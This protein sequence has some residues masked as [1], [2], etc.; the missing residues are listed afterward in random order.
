[1]SL[2]RPEVNS[3]VVGDSV[4]FE[5]GRTIKCLGRIVRVDDGI[6]I[7]VHD[8]KQ[9]VFSNSSIAKTGDTKNPESSTSTKQESANEPGPAKSS[10][11]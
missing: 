10:V 1:V 8:A 5:R 9:I 7:V 3:L 6:G 4:A 2:V 11:P